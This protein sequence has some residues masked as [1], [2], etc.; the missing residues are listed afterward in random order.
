MTTISITGVRRTLRISGQKN[1]ANMKTKSSK[2]KM[3]TPGLLL[4]KYPI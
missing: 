2:K 1:N 3:S 4:R